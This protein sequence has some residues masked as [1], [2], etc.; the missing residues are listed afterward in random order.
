MIREADY[1]LRAIIIVFKKGKHSKDND[2][3]TKC[4]RKSTHWV[5]IL[6]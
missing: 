6:Y 1:K 5:R 2:K 3:R 4:L